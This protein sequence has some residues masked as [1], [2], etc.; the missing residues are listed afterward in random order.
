MMIIT[1][2]F[3]QKRSERI[4]KARKR[5]QQETE[6]FLNSVNVLRKYDSIP[7]VGIV[8]ETDKCYLDYHIIKYPNCLKYELMMKKK[9][10]P[11]DIYYTREYYDFN[12]IPAKYQAVF[13]ELEQY[14]HTGQ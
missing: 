10:H 4:E 14:F 7:S 12:N 11:F 9:E 1:T 2:T 3:E 6:E 8:K 13:K 5:K